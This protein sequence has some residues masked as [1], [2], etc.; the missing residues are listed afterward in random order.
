MSPGFRD[1]IMVYDGY[2]RLM[3]YNRSPKSDLLNNGWRNELDKLLST[4]D[5]FCSDFQLRY[6]VNTPHG[7]IHTDHSKRISMFCLNS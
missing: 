7:L 3:F 2:K 4:G 6:L 1:D 5:E